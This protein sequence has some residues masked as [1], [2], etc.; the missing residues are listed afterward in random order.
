VV[1][2]VAVGA[3]PVSQSGSVGVLDLALTSSAPV[4]NTITRREIRAFISG[5]IDSARAI[6]AE[7]SVGSAAIHPSMPAE[8]IAQSRASVTP[9]T[10]DSRSSSGFSRSSSWWG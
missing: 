8:V 5:T 4:E 1:T 7:A 3:Q 6:A 2:A 9:G 10:R